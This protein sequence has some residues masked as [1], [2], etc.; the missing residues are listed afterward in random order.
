[1]QWIPKRVLT[2]Q[3]NYDGA[4]HI[5]IP[6]HKASKTLPIQQRPGQPPV[7]VQLPHTTKMGAKSKRQRSKH[8]AKDSKP[9]TLNYSAKNSDKGYNIRKGKMDT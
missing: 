1:M 8:Q 3:G 5:S 7:A 9:K 2:T 6:K 4:T